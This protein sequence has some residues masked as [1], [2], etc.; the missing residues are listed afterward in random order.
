MRASQVIELITNNTE[1][2]AGVISRL[3]HARW[4]IETFFKL[5][6]KKLNITSYLGINENAA[7]TQIWVAMIAALLLTYLKKQYGK[8][9]TTNGLGILHEGKPD[10]HI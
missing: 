5:I 9:W 10:E 1:W 8:N 2:K 6:N 4:E 7:P 3:Y